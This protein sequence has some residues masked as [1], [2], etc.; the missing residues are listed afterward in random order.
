MPSYSF[1]DLDV[2]FWR[3]LA[4]LLLCGVIGL[5]REVH[6]R[7]AGLRT[8]ILVGMGS[9]LLMMISVIVAGS[10]HDP[11]RIAAQVVTGIGFLGA[12]TIMR[13]SDHTEGLTTAAGVWAA[14]AVGLAAGLGWFEGATVTTAL[15]LLV[16]VLHGG[17][18]RR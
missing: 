17:R 9:C 2:V 1:P 18:F 8:H 4:A 12:G 14:S 13:Y 5:E 15:M 7:S 6:H 10:E 3:L 11:G 16:L